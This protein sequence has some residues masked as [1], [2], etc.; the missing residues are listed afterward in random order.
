MDY[1]K[2]SFHLEA[3]IQTETGPRFKDLSYS[4]ISVVIGGTKIEHALLDLGAS[5]NLLPHSVYEH[6]D[7]R[8]LKP[9]SVTL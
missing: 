3:I 8:E 1:T 7:L 4:T 9:T 2:E 6:L 5:V